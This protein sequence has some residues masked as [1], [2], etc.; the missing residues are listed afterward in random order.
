MDHAPVR[1]PLA[2]N[3]LSSRTLAALV[4]WTVR[5][6]RQRPAASACHGGDQAAARRHTAVGPWLCRLRG[7]GSA[8]GER[9]LDDGAC[10][11][12]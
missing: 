1:F 11:A 9:T 7:F 2:A 3:S 10:F 8:T 6:A 5:T 4:R 12:A